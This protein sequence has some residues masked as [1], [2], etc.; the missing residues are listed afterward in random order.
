MSDRNSSTS[1]S[2]TRSTAARGDQDKIRRYEKYVQLSE[3]IAKQE[4]SLNGMKD[5][6]QQQL[7]Q[8]RAEETWIQAAM[9]FQSQIVYHSS[10]IYIYFLLQDHLELTQ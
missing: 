9:S 7:A 2:T 6:L 5:A 10:F 8:L 1:T 3:Y 4:S